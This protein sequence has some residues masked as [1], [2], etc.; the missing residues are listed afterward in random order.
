MGLF[1]NFPYSNFHEIN[2]GWLIKTVE[3]ADKNV[4]QALASVMESEKEI[5]RLQEYVSTYFEN[6]DVTEE[7]NEKLEQMLL[8]G[9]LAEVIEIF[10]GLNSINVFN[11]VADMQAAE[12]LAE[13]SACQTLGFHTVGD[14]GGAI[15]KVVRVKSSTVVNNASTIPLYDETLVAVICSDNVSIKQLGAYGDGANDDT[16][17]FKTALEID[18]YVD[19]YI[20][21]GV[22]NISDTLTLSP[23]KNGKP[24]VFRGERNSVLKAVA[25]I[26]AVLQFTAP[27]EQLV[28]KNITI[29]CNAKA[30]R[31]IYDTSNRP[32]CWLHNLYIF[33]AVIAGIELGDENSGAGGH[34]WVDSCFIYNPKTF[35]AGIINYEPDTRISNSEIYY[36]SPAIDQ[37]SGFIMCSNSHF[38]SGG[39]SNPS[40]NTVCVTANAPGTLVLNFTGCYFDSYDT[41]FDM[42]DKNPNINIAGG[43]CYFSDKKT[44]ADYI[45]ILYVGL[46]AKWCITG[47][48]IKAGDISSKVYPVVFQNLKS[49][50]T[51]SPDVG[52]RFW[53][54]DGYPDYVSNLTPYH[55]R[56][57]KG[58]SVR[59]VL[60]RGMSVTAGE[61]LRI[62]YIF[63][64]NNGRF[65][66]DVENEDGLVF[67]N[68]KIQVSSTGNITSDNSKID[69]DGNWNF[70]LGAMENLD[71]A[72]QTVKALPLY[73]IAKKS[74][75]AEQGFV[76]SARNS[77]RWVNF[78]RMERVEG[79]PATVKIWDADQ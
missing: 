32:A 16:E 55:D 70:A 24:F 19:F 52:Y 44:Y 76:A 77:A 64:P 65:M 31:A 79:T 73:I 43:F 66:F 39:A 9:Q 51:Q 68:M 12:N 18:N 3:T 60:G 69:V 34:S 35:A 1:D 62:G 49:Y 27:G 56:A 25:E 78:F 40:I 47:F 57:L 45:K 72:G 20:P 42:P 14:G 38:W 4:Q 41:V 50:A 17:V 21:E 26:P 63:Q 28:V 33:N 30:S 10:L 48:S 36:C 5:A 67:F 74:I 59:S 54:V 15:Y 29:D 37:H 53:E 22:Y 71:I 8:S 61:Y 2:L 46:Y 23:E 58:D 75:T 6:L 11:T 13:G 7:I